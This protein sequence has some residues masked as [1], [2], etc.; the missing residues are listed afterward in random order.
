VDLYL[1][2]CEAIR[3]LVFES[4]LCY[5]NVISTVSNAWSNVTVMSLH[6]GVYF[7]FVD[8]GRPEF[9][10]CWLLLGGRKP[11]NRGV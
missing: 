10:A 6:F 9:V 5:L 11:L 8:V 3:W 4:V 2:P 7:S 1:S